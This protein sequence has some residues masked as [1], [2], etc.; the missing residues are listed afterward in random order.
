MNYHIVEARH[1]RAH[2]L[3]LRFRDGTAGEID[4]APELLG[5]VMEPLKDVAFF[6]TFAIHP[7]F[8]TLTWSNGADFAPEFLHDN[9]QVV[10]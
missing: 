2:T 1:V 10:A 7:E 5:P 4:L 9:V 8:H 6:A 3:W